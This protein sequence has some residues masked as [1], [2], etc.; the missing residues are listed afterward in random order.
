MCILYTV[1]RTQPCIEQNS[2]GLQPEQMKTKIKFE[3]I[4]F[5]LYFDYF[6]NVE[7]AHA[8][9]FYSYVTLDVSYVKWRQ[10]N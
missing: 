2:C 6:E 3:K 7:E 10:F 8:H 5:Y 4:W 1:H 9:S